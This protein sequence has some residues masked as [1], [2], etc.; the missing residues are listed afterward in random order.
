MVLG[1]R[2]LPDLQADLPVRRAGVRLYRWYLFV[3]AI[4]LL[5]SPTGGP[6]WAPVSAGSWHQ[7]E[8]VAT[9]GA[10]RV[11]PSETGVAASSKTGRDAVVY[12]GGR[13]HGGP[14]VEA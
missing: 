3:L 7:A 9:D 12:C 2:V 5:P 6:S 4:E 1:L 11:L 10:C 8:P 14:G 13:K